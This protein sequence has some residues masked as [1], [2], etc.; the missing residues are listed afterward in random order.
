MAGLMPVTPTGTGTP[1]APISNATD[2]AT[3]ANNFNTFLQLLTTQLQNQNPLDP[4]DTNQFTQQLVQFSGVEQALKT[5]DYL[6][7]L[8]SASAADRA[9]SAAGYLGATI[10]ADGSTTSL[11]DGKAGWTFS[12]SRPAA[13]ATITVLDASGQTV[14]TKSTALTAGP[15]SFNWDGRGDDGTLYTSGE[16]TLRIDAKDAIGSPVMVSTEVSGTVDAVDLSGDQPVLRIGN[17]SV[18]LDKVKTLRRSSP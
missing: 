16:Y 5:N 4:L 10:T 9:A 14:Y 17:L 1:S 15:G 3:L 2:Q 18:A 13:K 11:V 6:A 8:V 7:T 12:A